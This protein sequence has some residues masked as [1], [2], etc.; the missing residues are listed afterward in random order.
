MLVIPD[1]T[2][3]LHEP[4]QN[5]VDMA[6]AVLKIKKQDTKWIG[7]HK[8][9]VDSRRMPPKLVASVA[10]HLNDAA[11]EQK[12]AAKHKKARL[13]AEQHI[14]VSPGSEMLP[15]QIVV[16]GM[17]PAG[18]FAALELAKAGYR[19]LV[20]ERGPAIKER[21]KA[22]KAFESGADLDED[23]N[24][25]FGEGGAGTYSDGKLATRIGNPLCT[26]VM[27]QLVE[28]G[29]PEEVQYLS[30]PH[31][32]TDLLQGVLE[33]LRKKLEQLGGQVMFNTKLTGLV[34]KGNRL[35]SI[36]TSQGEI[37]C[38]VLVLA[39]GHSARDTFGVL[40]A[41]GVNL[42]PKAF[43]VGF[44]I[45]HLQQDIDK[46][47]YH[48]AAGHPALPAGEYRLTAKAGNRGVYT[49]CMCP[50]G[51]VVAAASEKNMVVTNGMSLH[52]RNGPNANSAVVAT[53]DQNDFGTGP[54]GGI[55]FQRKLE[56]AAYLM[57]GS[58]Y[59]APAE[60]L[61]SF[62][63]DG[64][65]IT[66]GT[67]APTY[68]R[69]VT[70]GNLS[71]LFPQ[72]VSDALKTG[73]RNFGRKLPGFDSQYA[74]LTGVETRTSSPVRIL[75]GENFESENIQGLWPCGEGAG[76]AGGIMSAAVDGIKVAHAIISRYKAPV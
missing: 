47:L 27:E 60:S 21:A 32:G 45:E 55:E 15:G 71:S 70:P 49:F 6:L 10:V 61:G 7:L 24:I 52:A 33:Q 28:A 57:G 35:E 1:I 25:Q 20:I 65:K 13:V 2:L 29:A 74:L 59:K 76:Y 18:L 41:S 9:S 19:P 46:G 39:I 72:E 23:A 14:E 63:E 54:F 36:A 43:A 50:G 42:I 22:I 26:K 4:A 34:V 16:C 3:K 66:R 30:R 31:I 48:E 5:A 12:L 58:G 64:G 69:G 44:R 75:R 73:L 37:N 17:G 53:V 68:S 51:S 40:N 11:L 56:H 8:L 38:G 62:F 67:V